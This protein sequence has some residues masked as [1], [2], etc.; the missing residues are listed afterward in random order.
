MSQ[1]SEAENMK[2]N[3]KISIS[4][5]N[6]IK[7]VFEDYINSVSYYKDIT[8]DYKKKLEKFQI[9]FGEN[10][11]EKYNIKY[12]EINKSHTYSIISSITKLVKKQIEQL[13]FIIKGIDSQL[14]NYKKFRET[15]ISSPKSHST[16]NDVSKDLLKKYQDIDDAR[17]NFNSCMDKT[18]L[19]L[20]KFIINNKSTSEKD[21]NK[22]ITNSKESA[23]KYI[24]LIN[25]VKPYEDN[26]DESYQSSIVK[27]E[28]LTSETSEKL[29][30]FV[31]DLILFFQSYNKILLSVIDFFLP[32]LSKLN[33]TQ[34]M[35]KIMKN[36]Y[37][38]DNKLCHVKRDKYEFKLFQDN[39]N[40]EE[41][42]KISDIILKLEDG[43]QEMIVIKDELL[44]NFLKTM[45]N[46]IDL[47]EYDF[48]IVIE[49]EKCKCNKLTEKV[50]EIETKK[51]FPT[52]EEVNQL[53]T[54]LDKH[55][56]RVV[57]LWKLSKYRS[58]GGF[59][60][61]SQTFNIFTK[62][63]Y[64]IID[65]IERDHDYFSVKYAIIISQTYYITQIDNEKLYLQAK[66]LY[67]KLFRSKKFW[68]DYL[69]YS[70][71][72]EIAKREHFDYENGTIGKE[73]Q[74]EAD[75]KRSSI[76]FTELVTFATNM[77]DFCLK[78]DIIQE[79]ISPK[80][81]EFKLSDDLR[82]SIE[83]IINGKK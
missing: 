1:Y 78:K 80:M 38:K 58:G 70:I 61:K 74:K 33:E 64:T 67:N 39:N 68:E 7:E 15:K 81:E 73:T 50:L 75:E 4:Y 45:K 10:L 34:E 21:V 41:D 14:E 32:E 83:D 3:M 49:E 82:V 46:E 77:T 17:Y 20:K 53:N 47:I 60:L 2:E 51:S 6:F 62:L 8:N 29:K 55:H 56:N 65:R 35:E 37:K 66:I 57:F 28:N 12:K 19:K 59:E 72:N 26:F 44:I 76:A 69:N 52:E 43:I 63:F 11:I 18:K 25:T 71:N 24:N 36:S 42:A 13:E 22:A 40:A 5:Y 23:K 27:M 9:E 79:V 31:F 30:D 54:L 16:F 48:D